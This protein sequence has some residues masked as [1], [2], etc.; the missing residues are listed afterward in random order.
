MWRAEFFV[1]LDCFLPFYPPNNPKNQNFEKLKKNPENIIILQMCTIKDNQIMYGF[2][3]IE[4]GRDFFVILDHFLPIYPLKTW[5]IKVLKKWKKHLEI[6]SFYTS[7]TEIMIICY[8]VPDMAHNKCNC[9]FHFGLFFCPFTSLTAQKIKIF[10]K[11]KNPLE[12]SSF[13]TCVPKIIIIC[14]TVPEIWCMTDVYS[15]FS[16]WA[17]FY[18]FTP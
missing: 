9:F 6:L 5:K 14:Y 10:K 16:F 3:D 7:L 13:Y 4:H 1:I 2:W 15:Y 8:T 12:I 17:I 11:W 18:P